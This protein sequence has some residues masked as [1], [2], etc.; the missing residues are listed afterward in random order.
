MLSLYSRLVSVLGCIC[1]REIRF[2]GKFNFDKRNLFYLTEHF[3][4]EIVTFYQFLKKF[5]FKFL[6]DPELSGKNF[7]RSVSGSCQLFRIWPDLDPQHCLGHLMT[8]TKMVPALPRVCHS[9]LW[10]FSACRQFF[11][12][13]SYFCTKLPAWQHVNR[14]CMMSK[15]QCRLKRRHL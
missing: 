15:R 5:Y 11:R 7:S 14:I 12:E 4:W 10:F 13:F 2:L 8:G 1:W 6:S 9:D 3:C